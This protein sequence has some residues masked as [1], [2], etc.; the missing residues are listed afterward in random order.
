M[1][2][3]RQYEMATAVQKHGGV[4][5]AA[6][7]LGLAEST[8][9]DA[10]NP[11]YRRRSDRAP[12]VAA[13]A[14]AYQ[15]PIVRD[16]PKVGAVKTYL[17]TTAQIN[18]EVHAE[19]WRNLQAFAAHFD[20][21][22]LVARTTYDQRAFARADLVKT[23]S[24]VERGEAL[25]WYPD[26]V[27]PFLCD[28][29]LKLAPK[30]QFAAELN[31]LP[32]ASRPLNGLAGYTGQ[33]STIVPHV[34]IALESV[35]RGRDEAPKFLYTTGACT[36]RNYVQ[37]RAGQIAEFHHA[38]GALLVEVASDGRWW[39][40]QINATN[41]G[42]FC[43][44]RLEISGGQVRAA[45]CVDGFQP[46]DI[47]AS[48]MPSDIRAGIWGSRGLLDTLRPKW[49]FHHDLLDFGA[50]SHHDRKSARR[51]YEICLAGQTV[52]GEVAATC[53]F[54]ERAARPWCQTIVV[55]SN[56][57]EHADRWLDEGD[58][59]EDPAN[60]ELWHS[61][62]A[63][64]RGAL[65]AGASWSFA[66][67]AFSG[68][69]AAR[70]LARDESFTLHEIE[71]GWHGDLGPNGSRGSTQSLL[72][73]CRRLSKGHDHQATIRDGVYSAGVC[74]R[75]LDYARGPSSWSI[76]HTVVYRNGKRAILTESGG[77]YWASR[78]SKKKLIK[79]GKSSK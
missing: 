2:T 67:W 8:V 44:L 74:A 65:R 16:L 60:S 46:G 57:N 72:R 63:A 45:E 73:T 69:G 31:I 34:K 14:V 37:K 19:F 1:T 29:R 49:Q 30:L 40:R 56:H 3:P 64:M 33:D 71:M 50:A 68:V 77:T 10:V 39:A 35:P 51:R 61:A 54:L 75:T 42:A 21:E 4:R 52:A 7:A 36:L 79:K 43:D 22:L 62:N 53:A 6:R 78:P 13:P 76:S 27:L 23:K 9:R 41:D 38:Y 11:R 26:E 24:A 70:V 32:T 15:K 5:P 59:R 55:P 25:Y 18:T 58:P 48:A 66:D 28:A 12:L 20:A 47:H 17:L